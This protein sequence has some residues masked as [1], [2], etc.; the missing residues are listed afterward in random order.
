MTIR[1]EDRP[2]WPEN[3]NSTPIRGWL[4]PAESLT[5][6]SVLHSYR[7]NGE[8]LAAVRID[9]GPEKGKVM[10]CPAFSVLMS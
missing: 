3:D 10:H 4:P 2:I 8:W 9:E 5:A 1:F 7:K 6:M